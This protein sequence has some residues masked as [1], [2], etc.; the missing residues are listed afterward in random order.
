VQRDTHE[1]I[2]DRMLFRKLIWL[3]IFQITSYTWLVGRRNRE[4]IGWSGDWWDG[5]SQGNGLMNLGGAVMW[6]CPRA[7]LS[8]HNRGCISCFNSKSH[9]DLM[10]IGEHIWSR[11]LWFNSAHD[12]GHLGH[13]FHIEAKII[14]FLRVILLIHK[15]VPCF[16]Y[17]YNSW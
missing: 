12:L 7:K 16:L 13:S 17:S 2:T 11:N 9:T 3:W 6:E 4:G 10:T 15:R 5:C 8:N 14:T 1:C